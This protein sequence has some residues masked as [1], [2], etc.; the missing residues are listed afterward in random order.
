M[1]T[2]KKV[3]VGK[4]VKMAKKAV[5]AAREK[6]GGSNIG[7]YKTVKKGDFAGPSGGAPKGT[8]PINTLKRA[9]NALARA[10]FAPNPEGI[11]RAVYKKY[12]ELKARKLAHEGKS[13]VAKAKAGQG[14]KD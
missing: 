10:H 14:K 2:T 6:K 8:F 13:A 11:K 7:Q 5:T 12:P 9:K 1:A 4:G 3:T